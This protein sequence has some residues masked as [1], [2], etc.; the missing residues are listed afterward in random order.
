[1]RELSL[2]LATRKPTFASSYEELIPD[3][4]SNIFALQTMLFSI[5]YTRFGSAM[6]TTTPLYHP[7]C[8][9]ITPT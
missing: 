3:I 2:P 9:Y 1:M 6:S 4:E 7:L 8:L 5:F